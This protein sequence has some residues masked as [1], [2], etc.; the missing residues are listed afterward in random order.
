MASTLDNQRYFSLL[1]I[2]GIS[3]DEIVEYARSQSPTWESTIARKFPLYVAAVAEEK[4]TSCFWD[5][6][7]ARV[8][9]ADGQTLEVD[10]QDIPA[11]E[12]AYSRAVETELL[13]AEYTVKKGRT[14]QSF[15]DGNKKTA[16]KHQNRDNLMNGNEDGD[17]EEDDDDFETVS[18]DEEETDDEQREAKENNKEHI[19]VS[20]ITTQLIAAIQLADQLGLTE[21]ELQSSF[22]D[23]VACKIPSSVSECIKLATNSSVLKLL[24]SQDQ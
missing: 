4:K 8:E 24:A 18:N 7:I 20:G 22:V 19:V 1:S 17:E 9:L 3:G 10:E 2:D 6:G 12:E 11:S 5:T 15:A 13:R 23:S 16:G 21:E 14:K